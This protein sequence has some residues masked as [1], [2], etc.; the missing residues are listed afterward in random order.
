MRRDARD[1]TAASLLLAAAAAAV[2]QPLLSPPTAWAAAVVSSST[3][4]VADL[5]TVEAAADFIATHCTVMLQAA[6]STGRLLYRGE[7]AF[8]SAAAQCSQSPATGGDD[9][10]FPAALAALMIK[11]P[12][13]LSSPPDLLDPATSGAAA[14]DY[15]LAV[16]EAMEAAQ[17]RQLQQ[18]PTVYVSPRTGHLATPD[19]V[20]ASQWGPVA[21]IWPLDP[22]RYATVGPTEATWWRDDWAQ[23]RGPRGPSFWRDPAALTAFLASQVREPPHLFSIYLLFSRFVC[24]A[25]HCSLVWRTHC[26]IVGAGGPGLGRGFGPRQRGAVPHRHP[27]ATTTRSAPAS[28]YN[29]EQRGEH[30]PCGADGAGRAVAGPLAGDPVLLDRQ[31][32]GAKRR[33]RGGRRHTPTHRPLGS[34]PSEADQPCR[35]PGRQ[36]TLIVLWFCD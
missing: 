29:T 5:R 13:L 18:P 4:V 34:R 15:F 21:S 32:H 36:V 14:A 2:G 16:S 19:P 8:I 24:C 31:D 25:A 20:A 17:R 9:A 28:H 27:A 12:L 22:L 11:R 26:V 33:G 7:P 6:R 3:T 30:V 23:L 10:T 1:R 35:Q